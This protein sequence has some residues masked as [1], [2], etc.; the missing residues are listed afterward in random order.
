MSE[1]KPVAPTFNY[2]VHVKDLNERFARLIKQLGSNNRSVKD[3]KTKDGKWLY[4]K[5]LRYKFETDFAYALHEI[6]QCPKYLQGKMF[7]NA[8]SIVNELITHLKNQRE[9]QQ[10]EKKAA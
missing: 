1:S 8:S 7:D 5:S 6:S 9:K 2:D 3:G 4:L 10:D